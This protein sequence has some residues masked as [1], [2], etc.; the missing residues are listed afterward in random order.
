MIA[1]AMKHEEPLRAENDSPIRLQFVMACAELSKK[2]ARAM[3]YELDVRPSDVVAIIDVAKLRKHWVGQ[4]AR[5]IRFF[6]P[7]DATF[8]V[9]VRE[10]DGQIAGHFSTF[11]P[12]D[13]TPYFIKGNKH[14]MRQLV[15]A[16]GGRN[17]D[18][19]IRLGYDDVD[20][21]VKAVNFGNPRKPQ[22]QPVKWPHL[23]LAQ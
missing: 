4:Q 17:R 19:P 23:V 13:N 6:V 9:L 7:E 2:R 12:K 21:E 16:T 1:A 14:P 8:A 10:K 22:I 5:N 18:W 11:L 3:A 15:D 20:E